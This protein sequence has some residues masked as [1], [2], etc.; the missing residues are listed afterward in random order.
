MEMEEVERY[1]LN[2]SQEERTGLIRELSKLDTTCTNFKE[3][4]Q[5]NSLWAC[6][7]NRD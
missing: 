4:S 6:L 7:N 2:I 3:F 1:K 5:L